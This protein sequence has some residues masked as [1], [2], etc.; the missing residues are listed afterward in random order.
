MRS[1]S[2]VVYRS[3]Q[4]QSQGESRDKEIRT[5]NLLVDRRRELTQL[6][7]RNLLL[8]HAVSVLNE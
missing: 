8:Q 4:I 6:K 3:T 1:Y 2:Q 5:A 7:N